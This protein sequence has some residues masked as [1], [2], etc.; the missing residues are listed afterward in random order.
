MPRIEFEGQTPLVLVGD[1]HLARFDGGRIAALE[2][3]LDRRV[4]VHNHA[5]GGTNSAD[6]VERA[7][8]EAAIRGASFVISVGTNDLAPWKRVPPAE[9]AANAATLLDVLGGRRCVV[10][11][12][13]TVD[14]A[15]QARSHGEL[16]RTNALVAEYGGLLARVSGEAGAPVVDLAALLAAE[17][18]VHEADGVH[19]N[20][21]GYA[22]LAGAIAA[23]VKRLVAD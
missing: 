1:S 16:G 3:A 10:V 9:F 21:H 11:L 23:A 7:P 2:F 5:I 6:L 4:V 22:L 14:E 17:R 20:R 15:S 19:L 12:P 13:P 18:D 8:A